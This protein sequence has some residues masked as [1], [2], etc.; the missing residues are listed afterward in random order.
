MQEPT[1]KPPLHSEVI[2]YVTVV[3]KKQPTSE[4]VYGHVK[5]FTFFNPFYINFADCVSIETCE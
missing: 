5:I 4:S 2:F 1:E 3:S